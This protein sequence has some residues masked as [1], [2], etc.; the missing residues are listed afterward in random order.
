M[1]KNTQEESKATIN[2]LLFVLWL[3]LI[4]PA[5]MWNAYVVQILWGWFVYPTYAIA[6]PQNL[7]L[8]AGLLMTIKHITWSPMIKKPN[9][10]TDYPLGASLVFTFLH[11]LILLFFGWIIHYLAS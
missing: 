8:L 1:N 5:A 2:L 11:P 6:L 3:I 10:D 7:L 9:A 4:I